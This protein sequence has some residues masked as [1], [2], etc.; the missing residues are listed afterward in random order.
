V[1]VAVL[2]IVL[3]S[4]IDSG[5]GRSSPPPAKTTPTATAPTGKRLS[6]PASSGSGSGRTLG[7]SGGASLQVLD[8][9]SVPNRLGGKLGAASPGSAISLGRL[10]GAPVVLN[11]WASDC[12]PC[13]AEAPTLQAEWQRLGPRGVLFLGLNVGDSSAVAKRF[14]AQYDITY[15]S[16]QE[17]RGETARALGSTGAPETFFIAKNGKVVGHVAGS[18]T[19]AQIE[20]GV[21]AAQTG[22]ETGN[23][24][25]GGRVPLP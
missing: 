10:R 21:R 3:A 11:V 2:A 1:P 7:E 23:D 24:E 4:L 17:K 12:T 25:G 16:L 22:R 8:R 18:I 9:G 19:L 20:L 5:D 13:R 6:P 15:P 14:R